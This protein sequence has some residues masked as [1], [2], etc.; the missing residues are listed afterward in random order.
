MEKRRAHRIRVSLPASYSSP[1]ISLD[2]MVSDLS[3]DGVFLRSEYL[4]SQGAAVNLRL[5]LPGAADAV[6]VEGEVVRIDETPLSSGMGIRFHR[7]PVTTRRRIA[8]FLLL[9]TSRA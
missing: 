4:D 1:A 2:A 3:C 8:N 6:R 7:V 5:Q 9:Q